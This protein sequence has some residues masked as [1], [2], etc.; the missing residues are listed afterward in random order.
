MVTL[1]K[2]AS[3]GSSDLWRILLITFALLA[4]PSFAKAGNA[5]EN[6]IENAQPCQALKVKT[7]LFTI[8]VD[9]F[10]IVEIE[11]FT[12][13]VQGDVATARAIGSL[14]GSVAN[15]SAHLPPG[16]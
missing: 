1:N 11:E 7:G 14:T 2:P 9:R 6:A 4:P 8:G 5:L 16:W 12:V 13:D 15:F 10:E 3:H